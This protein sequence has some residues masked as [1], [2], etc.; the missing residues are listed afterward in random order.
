[1]SKRS[2]ERWRRAWREGGVEALRS[3][4]RSGLGS[5]LRTRAASR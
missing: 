2:V 1:M 4:G 5:S 3:V